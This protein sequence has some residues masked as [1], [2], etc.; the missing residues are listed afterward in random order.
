MAPEPKLNE[1]HAPTA[2]FKI[3]A[4]SVSDITQEDP[5]GLVMVLVETHLDKIGVAKL[6]FDTNIKAPK[7]FKIGDEVKV[8]MVDNAIVTFQG[9]VTSI[10]YSNQG[11][12]A[13]VTLTAMDPLVKLAN[14]H[15]TK[16]WG[17]NPSDEIKD[18]DVASDVIQD[19]G[20]KA[21]TI[22]AT[23]GGRSY[24]LQRAESNLGF[25]KR[26]AGRNGYV[27]YAEEGKIH[28]MKPQFSNAPLEIGQADVLRLE[29]SVSDVG[30][31]SDITVNGWDYVKKKAVTG[32]ASASG[33]SKIG[34]GS[35]PS[36]VTWKGNL[37]ISDVFVSSDS[38]AKAMAEGEMERRGRS[39]VRGSVTVHLDGR[40]LPGVK[41][42]IADT[43][44]NMNAEGLIVGA[45]HIVEPGGVAETT[46]WF[47]GNTAPK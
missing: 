25:L 13:K 26:L 43:F 28:F 41:M 29:V 14:S 34:S 10:T 11:G 33:V 22:D 15:A 5:K 1:S 8:E 47:V 46:V 21:G 20:A 9:A 40:L 35:A 6:T 7:E 38:S 27:V 39:L 2:A 44:K 18:S 17:G 23:G 4:G 19:A 3:T 36:P 30:I 31:P 45:R 37:Q 12:N 42:K 16:H 32:Q 24:I